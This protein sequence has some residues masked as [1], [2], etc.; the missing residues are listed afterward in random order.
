MPQAAGQAVSA[1]L[2]DK[3]ETVQRSSG[4]V[5]QEAGL[6]ASANPT[7]KAMPRKRE[8]ETDTEVQMEGEALGG[9]VANAKR[10]HD[11]V[12][13]SPD[14]DVW[15]QISC[16]L[17]LSRSQAIA[18]VSAEGEEAG[19]QFPVCE[20]SW[21]VDREECFVDDV[22]GKILDPNGVRQA[23]KE[24][25]GIIQSMGIWEVVP[26]PPGVKIIGTRWVDVN[27]GD[28]D[29]PNHR[30]R[31]VAQEIKK[32]M[33]VGSGGEFDFFAAMPPLAAIKMLIAIAVTASIYDLNGNLCQNRG[34]YRISFV[35]IKRAHFYAAATR[36]I[37]VSLPEEAGEFPNMVGRLLKSMY[38]CR[39][40]GVNWELEIARVMTKFGFMQGLSSPCVYWHPDRDIRTAIHGDDFVSVGKAA[41][42]KWLHE[43]LA[44]EWTTVVRG[45]LGPPE[46]S[47]CC[48]EIVILNRLLTWT[49]E[50]VE[51][52][53]DPRHVDLL[54]EATG[55]T[56]AKISTP[57][58]KSKA[59]EEDDPELHAE[60]DD[61]LT[62][63]Y[64]SCTMRASYLSQDRPDLPFSTKELAK[65][66]SKP[67]VKH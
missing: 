13:V 36:E 48:H 21:N 25:M 35:D 10:K 63:I 58:V 2:A 22:S 19:D 9:E 57:V 56:G 44:K 61:S 47:E 51:W 54:V 37:Y 62:A 53:A 38:G 8:L 5:A 39:D 31:L 49:A 14:D 20:D 52:E 40:A 24:E 16:L 32:S 1:D 17:E 18:A 6:A 28:Q 33:Q 27:K 42:L 11:D 55:A 43:G 59:E 45:V 50:G 64:R 46:D 67:L 23:R 66:M 4:G 26:R 15:N 29:R 65:D 3:R 41:D 7:R 30:S 34:Q 12:T 60:L